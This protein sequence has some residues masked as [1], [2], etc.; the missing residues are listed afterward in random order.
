MR[1]IFCLVLLALL[2]PALTA[3]LPPAGSPARLT[4]LRW[5]ARP[6]EGTQ[7]VAMDADGA[8]KLERIDGGYL[9]LK[10]DGPGVLDTLA[11][12]DASAQIG[13]EADGQWVWSGVV[14]TAMDAKEGLFAP[15]LVYWYGNAACF[16]PPVG[17]RQTLRIVSN[18]ATLAR[19]IS[20]RTLPK[21]ASVE[22]ASADPKGAY[23]QGLA[24]AAA[25][26]K[27]GGP[28]FAGTVAP[29]ARAVTRDFLLR[30]GKTAPALTLTGSGEIVHL[31]FHCNPALTGSLREVVAEIR[32]DGAQEPQLRLPLP[33]LAGLPHPWPMGR[34]DAYN[35]TLGAGVRY[36]WMLPTPR[37][38]NQEATFHL[39]LPLPFAKGITIT[40]VNRSDQMQFAGYTR[41]VVLLLTEKEALASGR[42]CALRSVTPITDGDM[43]LLT[44]PVGGQL[45]GLGLFTSGGAFPSP[46]THNYRLTLT[47]EGGA[48][49]PAHL[50]ILPLWFRGAYGGGMGTSAILNH[51]RYEDQFAGVMR[52]FLTDPLPV[53][54]GTRLNF[55]T[56][57][58]GAG[59]PKE[60]IALA[61]WYAF[62]PYTAPALPA[63]AEP[64]PHTDYGSGPW[65][66]EAEELAP[67]ATAHGGELRIIEDTAH[68]YQ[69]S[70]GKYLLFAPD[71]AGDY[72]DIPAPMPATRYLTV[73]SNTLWGPNRGIY[74]AD[75]LSR[76]DAQHPPT[77]PQSDAY[78]RGRAVGDV[79]MKAGI[80][81]G[82]S[83]GHRRDPHP[84][85]TTPFLNPA[86]DGDGVIRFICQT[87]GLS[88]PGF[89]LALDRLQIATPPPTVKGWQECEEWAPE[90]AGDL[91]TS[92]PKYG[93]TAWSGWGALTLSSPVGGTATIKALLLLGPAKPAELRVKG[94]LGPKQGGWSVRVN[95]GPVTELRPG[96]DD[97]EV[98][99]WT[100]PAT[101]MILPG[102]ITLEFTCRQ[103]G[104]IV[105]SNA[106]APN[107]ELALDAW[108][109]K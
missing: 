5:L 24:A 14:R 65:L 40:L 70:K 77:F 74:E 23:Q 25:V 56:G 68:D 93:R 43:A 64:L 7:Q 75:I 1:A 18:K 39:N 80:L 46:V 82:E 84:T 36:P 86:P 13:I 101:D 3:P 31:E 62:T 52:H 108:G 10:V 67:M 28:G 33:D 71:Q 72:F 44:L 58:A 100:L 83:L 73:A 63:R 54:A 50:G 79:P 88:S 19:Y 66:W 8:Q 37:V 94:C 12:G 69:P 30:P 34:W 47:P 81:V 42:L 11:I 55:S 57:S 95:G 48:P 51:P 15:P 38:Y 61:F 16:L 104:E 41:A 60:A 96:K 90:T 17:F 102:P 98:V 29:P 35:G 22:T 6:L 45:V 107:A 49:L 53:Q 91:T 106:P 4:D 87:K 78:Y 27:Q 105:R 76:E 59:V 92:L 2:L 26:W 109:V 32:Y 21:G 89:L 97:Q 103:S 9:V 99:E 20:Y 85:P